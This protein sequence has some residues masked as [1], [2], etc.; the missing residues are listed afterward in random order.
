MMTAIR[1]YVAVAF[2]LL[3]AAILVV[4]ARADVVQPA[5]PTPA[6]L[7]TLLYEG[8]FDGI[9]LQGG[10]PSP[11]SG[12][13]RDITA[14]QTVDWMWAPL[15]LAAPDLVS[16]NKVLVPYQVTFPSNGLKTRHIL[17]GETLTRPGPTPKNLI[18][19]SFTGKTSE[20]DLK[21]TITGTIL[22]FPGKVF[23]FPVPP[24]V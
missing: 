22:P 7:S 17:P 5:P 8:D 14:V 23:P 11:A 12:D 2:A 1:R 24:K 10:C 9:L 4:P 15:R 16:L 6:D 13:L 21:F 19:C 3:A 20:G 18:A